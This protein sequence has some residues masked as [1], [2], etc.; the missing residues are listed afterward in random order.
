MPGSAPTHCRG[1]RRRS[2]ARGS[3]PGTV[4]RWCARL[5]TTGVGRPPLT[6]GD[7]ARGKVSLAELCSDGAALYWLESRPEENGRVVFVRAGADGPRDHSPAGVSIRSRVHEYGGGAVC[8]VPGGTAGDFAYVDQADQRVWFCNGPPGA[9]PGS[10]SP[11]PLSPE[12]PEGVAYRHGGL[13]ATADGRWVVAV[14]EAHVDGGRPLQRNIVA[15]STF[16]RNPLRVGTARRPRLLRGSRSRRGGGATGRRGLGT[17]EH[18]MGRLV[19]RRRP[20][21]PRRFLRPG[22]GRAHRNW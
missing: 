12:A 9:A 16:S 4:A 17:P 13:S 7:V 21:R 22:R 1:R 14:R 3:P 6:A 15:L 5:Q 8:L 19:A 2:P 11:R 10:A 18:A 20:T